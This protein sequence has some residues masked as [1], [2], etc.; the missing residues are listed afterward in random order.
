MMQPARQIRAISLMFRS[1]LNSSEAS[2]E[3]SQ[4]LSVGGDLAGV[5]GLAG[6]LDQ[7][8]PAAFEFQTSAR[9]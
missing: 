8:L 4:S 1:Y 6:G 5:Q 2:F 7:L 3:Q 9:G